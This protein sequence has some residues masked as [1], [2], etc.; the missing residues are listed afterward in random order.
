MKGLSQKTRRH[1]PR[2]GA[3]GL[4]RGLQRSGGES[5]KS[6]ST[7]KCPGKVNPRAKGQAWLSVVCPCPQHPREA[8]VICP[9]HRGQP[10]GLRHPGL[11]Q[12]QT[13]YPAE[14]R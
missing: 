14:D 2:V 12:G 11:H 5:G 10:D 13:E 3:G 9:S 7:E 4:L 6:M 1:V 8:G